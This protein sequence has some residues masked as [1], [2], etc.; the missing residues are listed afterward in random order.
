MSRNNTSPES[1]LLLAIDAL[2]DSIALQ[3][4]NDNDG[5]WYY[6]NVANLSAYRGLS[7]LDG[8]YS[9]PLFA[10]LSA[11]SSEDGQAISSS[12]DDVYTQ[13]RIL[14]EHCGQPSGLLSHGY[15]ATKSHSWAD[16]VTGASPIVWGRAQ[17]WYTLG[18]LNVLQSS[19]L[20]VCSPHI[21]IQLRQL[22]EDVAEPQL[23]AAQ[24][25]EAMT[26]SRFGVWQVVDRPWKPKNFIESSASFMST[27]SL[28]RAARLGFIPEFRHGRMS[29]TE[30]ATGIFY[31][32]YYEYLMKHANG[33]VSLT[34]TSKVA[35]L[36]EDVVDYEVWLSDPVGDGC[37]ALTIRP[38]TTFPRASRIIV[39]WGPV[40]LSWLVLRLHG[41][42]S[43]VES[44]WEENR[45]R[46]KG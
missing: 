35:S 30:L 13:F 15:D 42:K 19:A 41:W 39:C 43:T 32:N 44:G 45:I 26:G 24:D 20:D 18:L 1:S 4:R 34:G 37:V 8:M 9:Y 40:P 21:K 16:P 36:R 33:S 6:N 46:E 5:L 38:S 22:L 2:Q 29:V 28:M 12:C 25:S 23:I 14:Y 11:A 3:P 31:S 27:Y 10:I 7:Y 17:A